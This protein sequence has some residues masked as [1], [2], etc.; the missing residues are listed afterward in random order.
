MGSSSVVPGQTL[1][2]GLL[3]MQS[4]SPLFPPNADWD[5]HFN[6]IP[7]SCIYPEAYLALKGSPFVVRVASSPVCKNSAQ[8]AQ[9][10]GFC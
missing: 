10:P 3:K 6:K 1:F 8:N 9:E 7:G 4:L 5:L 2:R